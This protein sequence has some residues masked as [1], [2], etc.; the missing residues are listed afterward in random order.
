VIAAIW[1]S[2]SDIAK[3]E[4]DGVILSEAV[5]Q[6]ERRISR[7]AAARSTRARSLAPLVKARGFGM[8]PGKWT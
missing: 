2:N 5:V 8:T 1:A 6:A 4:L 3:L 7:G